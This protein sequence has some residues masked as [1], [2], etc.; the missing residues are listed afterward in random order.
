MHQDNKC[1]NIYIYFFE[2]EMEWCFKSTIFKR[3]YN[4][5]GW[6]SLWSHKYIYKMMELMKYDFFQS[7]VIGYENKNPKSFKL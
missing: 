4:I 2:N 5:S 7:K 6:T 3:I 1:K